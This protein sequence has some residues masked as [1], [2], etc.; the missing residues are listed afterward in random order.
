MRLF[1]TINYVNGRHDLVLPVV[2]VGRYDNEEHGRARRG[3]D[4]V[5]LTRHN[6]VGGSGRPTGKD[7]ALHN[8]RPG[9]AKS[10]GTYKYEKGV[11]RHHNRSRARSMRHMAW[12]KAR[13]SRRAP[14]ITSPSVRR[15]RHS[16][17]VP[18]PARP[19]SPHRT[20]AVE[21]PRSTPSRA[22]RALSSA[23]WAVGTPQGWTATS[24]AAATTTYVLNE[25]AAQ[26]ANLRDA[27]SHRAGA[28]S[29]PAA[30]G[31]LN[32]AAEGADFGRA[33]TTG[34][35]R[36]V[37]AVGTGVTFYDGYSGARKSGAGVGPATVRGG[38]DVGYSA[39]G[40]YAGAACGFP[41]ALACVPAGAAVG[42]YVG[43]GAEAILREGPNAGNSLP[44][45]P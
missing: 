42:P 28:A 24:S 29:S 39:I 4:P 8:A 11:K 1:A 35:S 9:A 34:A 20:P 26:L 31:L 16:F 23:G 17:R 2:P 32:G 38:A 18:P 44:S 3:V 25:G 41:A 5:S 36:S 13:Y 14:S 33:A 43:R 27:A 12:W 30:R 15:A 45:S 40:A 10:Y 21:R 19:R 37:A 22:S 7:T 6:S